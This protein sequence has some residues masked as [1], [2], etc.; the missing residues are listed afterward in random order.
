MASQGPFNVTAM[1]N[2]AGAGT[3]WSVAATASIFL[4][5]SGVSD[6]L[7]LT[8]FT[9]FNIPTGATIDGIKLEILREAGGG[10]VGV[11]ED[12]FVYLLKGGVQAG[13]D[14]HITGAWPLGT[15][16]YAVYG[17]SS[18]LWG[19]SWTPAQINASDF[20]ALLKVF[21]TSNTDTSS[22][23]VDFQSRMTVY[24]TPPAGRSFAVGFLGA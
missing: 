6:F 7:S 3:D 19:T 21:E 17:S 10:D 23:D 9:G 20:G 11:T 16:E 18:D 12:N 14:H 2:V 4:A 22:G 13:I 8:A 24:Y 15:F 5:A 1:A